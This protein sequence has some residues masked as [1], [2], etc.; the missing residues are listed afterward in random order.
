MTTENLTTD[1]L[2]RAKKLFNDA[3]VIL[4]D[5]EFPADQIALIAYDEATAKVTVTIGIFASLVLGLGVAV[6][7]SKNA[8][9]VDSLGVVVIG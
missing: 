1:Q 6:D 5:A 8:I 2:E 3:L 4:A 7:I 9:P